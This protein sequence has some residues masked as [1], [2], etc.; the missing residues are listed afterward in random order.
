MLKISKSSFQRVRKNEPK[1][2]L[3]ML[4]E[5]T[6]VKLLTKVI[7]KPKIQIRMMSEKLRPS[8]NVLDFTILYKTFN[9]LIFNL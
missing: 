3:K 1:I 5:M 9:K 4:L 6:E 8:P 2:R 7:I